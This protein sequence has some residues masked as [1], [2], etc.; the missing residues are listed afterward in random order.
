MAVLSLSLNSDHQVI[1]GAGGGTDAIFAHRDGQEAVT[2]IVGE[3]VSDEEAE[4]TAMR[5]TDEVVS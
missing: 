2:L 1:E 4:R 5:I 3:A